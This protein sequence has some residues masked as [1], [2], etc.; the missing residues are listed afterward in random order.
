[1]FI[2]ITSETCFDLFIRLPKNLTYFLVSNVLQIVRI[3]RGQNV[4]FY[5]VYEYKIT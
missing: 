4:N 5:Q 1:M 3:L 2:F